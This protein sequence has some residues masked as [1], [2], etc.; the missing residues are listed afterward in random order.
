MNQEMMQA[1]YHR[2]NTVLKMPWMTL[3]AFIFLLQ[4]S[5]DVQLRWGSEVEMPILAFVTSRLDQSCNIWKIK[6]QATSVGN[7]KWKLK[8]LETL[9]GPDSSSD[10]ESMTWNANSFSFYG[11]VFPAFSVLVAGLPHPIYP[12][13]K[14]FQKFAAHVLT[15]PKSNESQYLLTK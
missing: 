9:S 8:M 12:K 13:L 2:I 1:V 3:R 14:P 15:L 7:L 4:C 10:D 6:I 11:C 5:L